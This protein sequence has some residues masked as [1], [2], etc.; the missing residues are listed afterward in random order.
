MPAETL[1]TL[2]TE[3]LLLRPYR[4]E[5]FD[6]YAALWADPVVTSFIGGQP[7]TREQSWSRFLRHPGMWTFLGFGSFGVYDRR[8]G[9]HLGE[10]GFHDMKRDLAPSITGTME[11]GWAFFP[12]AHGTG[13]A[14]EAVRAV[15]GWADANRPE[16]RV[17]CFVDP[18][19]PASLRVAEKVGFREFARGD[20]LG[21]PVILFERK[22]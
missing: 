20:Y 1:P 16:M 3:R 11:T 2:E 15:L 8:T 10:A 19:N 22:A 7:F 13:I 14:T 12:A 6:S 17:T 5:E 4:V 21:K 9:R 18:G